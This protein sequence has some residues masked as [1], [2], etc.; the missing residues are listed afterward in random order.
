MMFKLTHVT[1]VVYDMYAHCIPQGITKTLFKRDRR[2]R[3]DFVANFLDYKCGKNYQNRAWFDKVI[4]KIKWC[5][6]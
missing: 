1:G 6:F 3:Y 2:S 4:A 5:S